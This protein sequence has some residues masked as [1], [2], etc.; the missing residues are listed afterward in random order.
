MQE[1]SASNITDYNNKQTNKQTNNQ[2]KQTNKHK[3][4]K[5]KKKNCKDYQF[6]S[7][8][9]REMSN[10]NESNKVP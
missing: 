4:K 8:L 9:T 2:S 5:K 10:E 1:I 6:K 7:S 3:K